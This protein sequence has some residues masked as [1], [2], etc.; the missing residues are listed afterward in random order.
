MA[1]LLFRQNWMIFFT[2]FTTL[3]CLFV[4]GPDRN[5]L[6]Y[7]HYSYTFKPGNAPVFSGIFY[8]YRIE[9][10]YLMHRL[11][12]ERSFRKEYWIKKGLPKKRRLKPL[13]RLN[14]LYK[15]NKISLAL[16]PTVK[17]SHDANWCSGL[18]KNLSLF[19]IS[20]PSASIG[21]YFRA[22]LKKF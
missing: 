20:I 1:N 3:L 9:L 2:V 13:V 14:L 17:S 15:M 18:S 16:L 5:G 21:C 8:R 7:L 6:A 19:Y 12:K 11:E 4:L 22:C 10:Q